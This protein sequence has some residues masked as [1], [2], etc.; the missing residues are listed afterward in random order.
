[1]F[2]RWKWRTLVALLVQPAMRVVFFILCMYMRCIRASPSFNTCL[3]SC[4][5]PYGGI[6]WY[7]LHKNRPCLRKTCLQYGSTRYA[8]IASPELCEAKRLI[9]TLPRWCRH[10]LVERARL[11][12]CVLGVHRIGIGGWFVLG[13]L[14]PCRAKCARS[15]LPSWWHRQCNT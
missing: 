1:M 11:W 9:Q 10:R 3:L 8:G 4:L 13:H 5:T 12:H 2:F 15:I 6:K 14:C 7:A